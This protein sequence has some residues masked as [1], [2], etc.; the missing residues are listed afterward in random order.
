M[1]NYTDTQL[2][3][4]VNLSGAVSWRRWP[5]PEVID[6]G[7]ALFRE[8][9]AA[10]D[11]FWIL[12]GVI[13]LVG[14]AAT[15]G[16]RRG[17]SL[18]GPFMDGHP[19]LYQVSAIAIAPTRLYRFA[20]ADFRERLADPAF[21][22]S[23]RPAMSHALQA[24]LEDYTRGFLRDPEQRLAALLSNFVQET[25]AAGE[26]VQV[27]LP[28]GIDTGDL[29]A[30][31]RVTSAELTHLLDAWGQRGFARCERDGFTFCWTSLNGAV[32]RTTVSAA[33][34]PPALPAPSF[35]AEPGRVLPDARVIKALTL[36]DNGYSR[37]DFGLGE[38]GREMKLPVWHLARLLK[39]ATGMTFGQLRNT[40][41]VER[42]RVALLTTELSVKEI[43]AG[44]GYTHPTDLTR[45]FRAVHAVSPIA[46]RA[47]VRRGA[48]GVPPLR[49][50]MP[51][52]ATAIR[53]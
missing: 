42:A 28:R 32:R 30:L 38:L 22:E 12:D 9:S 18:L 50:A 37:E 7:G 43:A 35:E 1:P 40:V 2:V 5:R 8:G 46:Y 17:R 27:A 39:A 51:L 24:D 21:M 19:P 31:L 36:I 26:C 47:Q 48:I 49:S 53:Q 29:A 11:V 44:V 34:E 13:K 20:E 15:R 23:A 52:I 3:S 45:Q 10:G 6:A 33:V 14:A 4:D 16:L 41:R 25:V